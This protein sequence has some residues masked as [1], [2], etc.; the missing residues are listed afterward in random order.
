LGSGLVGDV[1]AQLGIW[2]FILGCGG[3]VQG[4]LMAQLARMRWLTVGYCHWETPD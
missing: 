4:D 1:V 2:W 3:S